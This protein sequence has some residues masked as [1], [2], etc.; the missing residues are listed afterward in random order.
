M[1]PAPSDNGLAP[2]P[3]PPVDESIKTM[4]ESS[5]YKQRI[6]TAVYDLPETLGGKEASAVE[7]YLKTPQDGKDGDFRQQEY[8]LRNY[9][10][11]ALRAN[12]DRLSETIST[13]V[14]VASDNRQGDVMRGY[15]LQHLCSVYIDNF[16]TLSGEDKREIIDTFSLFLNESSAG[17]VAGT[18]LIGLHEASRADSTSVAGKAVETAA[19]KLLQNSE[20]GAL[21]KISAFQ[22]CGE[23]KTAGVA[24]LARKTALDTSADWVLRMSAVYALGQLGQTDGLESLLN[25]PDKN[26]SHAARV[27]LNTQR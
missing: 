8:A 9:M 11:D 23:R 20:S 15:A 2:P 17:T 4:L 6:Q 14:D 3:L 1:Q 22:I 16:R 25:D 10:M 12:T 26:V 21:S 18:A 24:Q 7:A 19:L 13:F 5:S 27:A